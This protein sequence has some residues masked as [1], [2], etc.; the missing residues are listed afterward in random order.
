VA[1][2]NQQQV[3]NYASRKGISVEQAERLLSPNL[4]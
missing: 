2:I 3:E 1:K 4:E